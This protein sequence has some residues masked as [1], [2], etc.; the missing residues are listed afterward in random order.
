MRSCPTPDY[1]AGSHRNCYRP[2]REKTQLARP[3]PGKPTDTKPI[4]RILSSCSFSSCHGT[5]ESAARSRPTGSHP[6]VAK[7][8]GC[9]AKRLCPFQVT[10]SEDGGGAAG[11]LLR[12][13]GVVLGG[14]ESLTPRALG[15]F[16]VGLPRCALIS[17]PLRAA[18]CAT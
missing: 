12:R 2:T 9:F 13:V 3:S 15:H 16:T 6:I 11:C 10:P 8:E 17:Q 1:T 7:A 4:R 14:W 5:G 18:L